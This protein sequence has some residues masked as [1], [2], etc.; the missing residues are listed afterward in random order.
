MRPNARPRGTAEEVSHAAGTY[1]HEHLHKL[2]TGDGEEG[3]AGFTGHG[4]GQ[5][6]LPRPRRPDEQHATGDFR[7]KALEFR[8]VFQELDNLPQLGFRPFRS[9][10]IIEGHAGGLRGVHPCAAA[11]EAQYVRS[12]ARSPSQEDVCQQEQ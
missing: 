7:S 8:R 12:T 5:Q 10:H 6:R 4:T 1:T 11:S 9:G 3:N 2:G